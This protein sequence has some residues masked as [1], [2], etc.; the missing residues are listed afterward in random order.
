MDTKYTE[1]RLHNDGLNMGHSS[2]NYLQ[3]TTNNEVSGVKATTKISISSSKT[4]RDALSEKS[5]DLLSATG[6]QDGFYGNESAVSLSEDPGKPENNL[7]S[8][9]PLCQADFH[10]L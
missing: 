7:L 8:S 5:G 2:G 3:T 6:R 9:C 10:A 1:K 4:P